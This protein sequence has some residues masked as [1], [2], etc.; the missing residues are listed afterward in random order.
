MEKNKLKQVSLDTALLAEL[1]D[2]FS[3]S[4]LF[5]VISSPPS[6]PLAN[7]LAF[8]SR[9]ITLPYPRKPPRPAHLYRPC[10]PPRRRS[11][12]VTPTAPEFTLKMPS[13]RRPKVSTSSVSHHGSMPSPVGSRRR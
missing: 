4:G 6:L 3:F 2:H 7:L 12:K 9:F 1:T 13:E 10:S 5:L 11:Q 8:L